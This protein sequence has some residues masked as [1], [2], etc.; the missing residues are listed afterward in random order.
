MPFG[1][2]SRDDINKMLQRYHMQ[3]CKLMDTHLERNLS[4]SLDMC[5]KSTEEKEQMSKVPYFNAIRSLMYAI[6]CTRPDI[7]Y[8]VGLE[9]IFQSN[10]GIKHG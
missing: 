6:M 8:V 9:S 1:F 10:I 2:I 7:C 4:L 5:P 3:D